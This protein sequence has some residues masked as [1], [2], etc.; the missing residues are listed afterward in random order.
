M[1]QN[2]RK[3]VFKRPRFRNRP[4]KPEQHRELLI[5]PIASRTEMRVMAYSPDKT[6]EKHFP[7]L[8]EV[9]ALQADYAV[10]WLDIAGLK[11]VP[12]IERIGREF[13]IHSLVMEDVVRTHQRPKI[14]D[15]PDALFIVARMAPTGE[16]TETEQFSLYL[17]GN[18]LITFQEFPDD[19]L[20]GVRN[21]IRQNRGRIR[22]Q[23]ADYLVYA[24]VDAIID[25][26]FPMVDTYGE[27]IEK[28]EDQLVAKPDHALLGEIYSIRRKVLELRRAMWPHREMLANLYR[29]DSNLVRP[30]TQV[31]FRDCYDHTVQL[32]DLMENYRELTS[33]L[34][35]VYLSSV[36]NRLNEIM[37]VLTIIS[38]VFI[39]LTFIVGVYGMNFN[40]ASSPYNMP[41]LNAKYGYPLVMGFMLL[42]VIGQVIF[43]SRK[44]WLKGEQ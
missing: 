13:K 30:E 25:A 42:M 2:L 6:V 20:D 19:D 4:S 33:T 31:F 27:V 43:F 1:S 32:M 12:L 44:G 29:G 8:D 9:K 28:L 24:L 22:T 23:Q 18:C 7:S 38:V 39:P 37:K 3:K 10:V 35:E 40:P 34:M 5:D 21:R 26:Y 14:E 11:D 16:Q 15:Y 41:E 17:V 36:S